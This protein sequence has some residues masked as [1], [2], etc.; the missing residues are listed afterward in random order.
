MPKHSD[1]F[2]HLNRSSAS[3]GRTKKELTKVRS[4]SSMYIPGV[5]T[6]VIRPIEKSEAKIQV[7]LMDRNANQVSV[8]KITIISL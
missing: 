8:Y 4:V 1:V 6:S 2:V 5:R 3:N 7:F